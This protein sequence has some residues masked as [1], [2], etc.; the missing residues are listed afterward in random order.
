M[1]LDMGKTETQELENRIAIIMEHLLK[2]SYVKGQIGLDNARGWNKTVEAQQKDLASLI[3]RNPALTANFK[4]FGKADAL[5]D[6][7]YV[8]ALRDARKDYPNFSF[9]KERHILLEDILGPKLH[10]H[11]LS[12]LE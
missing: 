8:L 1:M 4:E 11:L 3:K 5:A 12:A 10:R 7:M 2:L 9:P 6:K